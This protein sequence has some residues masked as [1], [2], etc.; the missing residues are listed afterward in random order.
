MYCDFRL[1][2]AV[3]D[4]TG[5]W[6]STQDGEEWACVK[7]SNIEY[8]C[9]HVTGRITVVGKLVTPWYGEKGTFVGANRIEFPGFQ[10]E[11]LVGKQNIIYHIEYIK[12]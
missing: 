5:T 2:I 8:S 4:L 7:I 10:W 3:H 9:N 11:K 1:E 6:K 12:V